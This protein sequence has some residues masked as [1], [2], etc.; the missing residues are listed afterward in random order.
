MK[1]PGGGVFK[2]F[3][4]ATTS[5]LDERPDYC[6]PKVYLISTD[7][8]TTLHYYTQKHVKDHEIQLKN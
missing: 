1:W 7:I 8:N 2:F 4:N 3:F 6:C 5:K